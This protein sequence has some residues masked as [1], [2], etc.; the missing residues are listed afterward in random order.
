MKRFEKKKTRRKLHDIG[1]EKLDF[2]E[3]WKKIARLCGSQLY[4][5]YL[6][7]GDQ[8]DQG[9]RPVLPKGQKTPISK[10]GI[11]LSPQLQQEA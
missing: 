2:I 5:T 6:Q 11:C 3:I 1:L 4:P 7:N 8:E 10:N 9:L